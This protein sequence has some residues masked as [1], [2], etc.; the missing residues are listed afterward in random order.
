M[1]KQRVNIAIIE[2]SIIIYEGLYNI[3][4]K[5]L[6]NSF[7]YWFNDLSEFEEE[8]ES[9]SYNIVFVNPVVFVN[10]INEFHK[11]RKRAHGSIWIALLHSLHDNNLLGKFDEVI[12]IYDDSEALNQKI[13]KSIEQNDNQDKD[14]EELSEREVEVLKQLVRGFSNKEIA[15]S[16]NISIHTVISHRKR[17]VEKT[18]IKSLPG[19]TIFAISKNVIPMDASTL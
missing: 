12:S 7:V 14:F 3:L 9:G 2:P 6:E 17:I 1:D 5:S 11:L 16:L 19:L 8:C 10:R 15:N 18:G 4:M 13:S